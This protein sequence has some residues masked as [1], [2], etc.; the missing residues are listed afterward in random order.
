MI[1]DKDFVDLGW[2]PVPMKIDLDNEP[3]IGSVPVYEKGNYFVTIQPSGKFN[4]GLRL[5]RIIV[6]DLGI[7]TG[8]DQT[9]A[10]LYEGHVPSKQ[11]FM[12][13]EATYCL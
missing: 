4:R 2:D 12:E 5:L 9:H 3:E 1:T 6:K 8:E 11:Q 13:L 10:V 7:Y